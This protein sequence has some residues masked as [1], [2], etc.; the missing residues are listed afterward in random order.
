MKYHTRKKALILLADG[1]VFYGKAV[2]DQAGSAYGEVCF[3]TGMSGYQELMTDPSGRGQ[4]MIATSAHVGGYGVNNEE[5][6]SAQTHLAGLVVRNFGYYN[7]RTAS[8]GTLEEFLIKNN[9]LAISDVDTRALTQHVLKNGAM[10]GVISTEV[11]NLDEL[12]KKLSKM[13][14]VDTVDK[15]AEVSTAEAYFYGQESSKHKVAVLDLGIKK[16]FLDRLAQQDCYIKV[17]PYTAT[18][19]E[20]KDFNPRGYFISNGPGNPSLLK[21]TQSLV[22]EIIE[23]GK[24]VFGVCLGHQLIGLS[25]GIAVD[26]MKNGHRGLNHP[27]KNLSS[28]KGEITTQN[29]GFVLNRKDAEANED[30]EIT[31]VNLNDQSVAGIQLKGKPVFSVQY[32]PGARPGPE[33][34]LYLYDQFLSYF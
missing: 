17:F 3:N 10:N 16:S 1:T 19:K 21:E 31:H 33:D 32:H 11:D 23:S 14:D 8:D 29:N 2:G 26:K 6:V 27:I 30:V 12:K 9:L 24:P 28:G 13:A 22:A 34:S 7:S 15:V 5:M 4:I 25:Q 20:M 18:F